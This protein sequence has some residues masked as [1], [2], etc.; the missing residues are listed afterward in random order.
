MVEFS[1][2]FDSEID[3]FQKKAKVRLPATVTPRP[4]G[5]VANLS[6]KPR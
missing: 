6:L 2:L 5:S 4:I 1:E 3:E